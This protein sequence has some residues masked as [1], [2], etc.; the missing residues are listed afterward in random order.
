MASLSSLKTSVRARPAA[1]R[2]AASA[3]AVQTRAV[4]SPSSPAKT[5]TETIV[6]PGYGQNVFRGAVADGYLSKYGESAKMLDDPSWAK[7]VKKAD[8]VAKAL[9]DWALDRGATVFCHCFQP[10]GACGVRHGQV[11]MVQMSMLEFGPDGKP[12]YE[13]E[14]KTILK[15]ETDGSSFPN[16]GMRATHTAGGYLALD[17]VS[18]VFLREDTIFLPA[19]FVA[20]TGQ[21]LD[22]KTPLHRAVQAMSTEGARLMKKLGVECTGMVNNIG[23]EQEFF[24]VPREEYYMRPDLQLTGRSVMG[25]FPARGQEM[26]DHY[27][28][29][30]TTSTPALEAMRE[31]QDECF[32]LGIPLKTRHREVAPNQYEMAPLFGNAIVQTD[33]N[34]MVMQIVEEVAAKYGLA[35]LLHEKPFAEI[36]GS[37]KHNNWSLS[38]NEGAQLLNPPQ[39][40]A[41]TGNDMVF[42]VVMAALVSGIDKHGDLMRM[43]IASPGN[44]FRLGAMEAPPA[45]MS[46][47]LGD[48]MTTYLKAFS[49]GGPAAYTPQTKTL[50]FGA[51]AIAP[52]EVPAE[53]RNRTSPFPYGGAR[54]EFRACGSSQNVSLINTVLNTI[55]AEGFKTISDR[56]DAGESVDAVARDLLSKHMRVVFNGNGYDPAWP[57]KAVELGIWRIDSGVEAMK[58]FNDTKNVELFEK[59]GVLTG[60]ECE[61]RRAVLLEHYVGTVEMEA[62][63]M[64]DMIRQHV[65]PCCN[66]AGVGDRRAIQKGMERIEKSLKEVEEAE[67]EAA[68]ATLARELRLDTM[69][70]VREA[71]DAAE[72]ECPPA[73]WTL[74]TYENLLFL[75]T[76]EF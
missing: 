30:P 22:E 56:V 15:G 10:M 52:I 61:A 4:A 5:T 18:P 49:E 75:D 21:A 27:M 26:S 66:D 60:E 43:S 68:K 67:D 74:G 71:C 73:K 65:L 64:C 70:K 8:V 62:K 6:G 69:I 46:M 58:R 32:K 2:A 29:P 9:V 20:Y 33:Q 53:D 63:V 7:D 23:L 37:G 3:R 25:A 40:L 14:G 34:L 72:K 31:I 54:F 12:Y 19:C 1:S 38:T 50:S 47:Y 57:E 16:G 42:P 13:L 24:L 48:D 39:L 17:P 76:H 36:N 55:A 35:A 45:V 28:G 41:K 11:G 59:M 51:D 44:D